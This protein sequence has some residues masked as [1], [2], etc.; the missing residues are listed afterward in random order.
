MSD[1]TAIR[2]VPRIGDVIEI[3]T[4]KGFAYAQFTH[5]HDTPPK[6][7]ALL[8]V[9]PTL[10]AARP[11]SFSAVVLEKPQIITFFPL[12]AACRRKI[13]YIVANEAIPKAA[14]KFPIFRAGAVGKDGKVA[15]WWLWDGQREWKAGRITRKLTSYPIR[16]VWNDT[17]LI[18]RIVEGWSHEDV[19]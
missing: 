15:T 19:R 9:F 6:Y 5:K 1:R 14:Q 11:H 3:E 18:T 16:G 12:G 2:T 8:R 17:L 7:G 4:P 10:H 13:V